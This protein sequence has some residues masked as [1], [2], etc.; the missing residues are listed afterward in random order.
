MRLPH[1][2]LPGALL[3]LATPL[4]AQQLARQDLALLDVTRGEA[5]VRRELALGKD[6]LERA[7]GTN[8]WALYREAVRHFEQAALD[9]PGA[10]EPWFGL[11][12]TRLALY[13]TGA[14]PVF[15][16]TQPPGQDTREAWARDIRSALVRQ[17]DHLGALTSLTHVVLPQGDRSQPDW[18][19]EVIEAAPAVPGAPNDLQLVRGRLLRQEARY[20]DA[21][22]ALDAYVAGGGDPSVAAYERA[23]ALAGAG[24]LA[25][26]AAAYDAGLAALTPAGRDA[27]LRDL[28]WITEPAELAPL[29]RITDPAAT[30][31]AIARFWSARDAAD[32]R[33]EGERLRE[34][35]RRWAV[36]ERRY[37]VQ[38]PERRTLFHEPWAPIAPCV[39]RDSFS[40]SQAGTREGVDP[41]DPRRAERILDDRGLMYL[42]HGEPLRVV[43]T[44]GAGDR[45]QEEAAKV[46]RAELEASGIPRDL[47]EA[48][49]GLR[50][51]TGDLLG[52]T[53]T[54]EV[55]T[56]FID[57]RVRSFLFTGSRW[58]GN[59][60]PTTLSANTGSGELALLR[61]QVDP[62]YYTVWSRYENPFPPK[63]PVECLPSV[64]RMARV[65]REDLV[66]GGSSD[67]APLV[68]P[69][70]ALP[71]VQVAAV[72]DAA[73][74]AGRA[75]VAW[76]IP[77]D[78]LVPARTEH[79]VV[80][81][82][83][84]RLTAVDS[85]GDV[86]RAEGELQLAAQDS[87]V[88]GQ[89]LSGTLELPL[90]AGA[91]QVGVAFWQPDERHGGAV[92]VKEVRLATGAVTLSD[93]LLGR[94]EELVR[95]NGVPVNPLNTW[96]RDGTMQVYAELRGVPAGAEYRAAIEVR[97]LD[98]A[99]GR[100]LVSVT[101]QAR[102]DGAVTLF[103]RTLDLGRLRPGTYRLTLR[104][105]APGGT[106]LARERVFEIL[107]P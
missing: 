49:L 31:R 101:S 60:A 92:Q 2:A 50:Q 58:L 25:A 105:T 107:A 61:A 38:D 33:G 52:G 45:A 85:A 70:P 10:A 6:A 84:W 48:E 21:L 57:G 64:Q 78:H 94:E 80:Y 44:S 81:P 75:A 104:V 71:S 17:P 66:A 39:P 98:H 77:G 63:V 23:R 102:S 86:H 24:D 95:W 73:Q 28:A 90:P 89:F 56:Y 83:R 42:R 65:A 40:L 5:A 96:R 9:D 91:W 26:A 30:A 55:W 88:A 19:R 106:E 8:D 43:W 37:R 99:R 3:L 103:R 59:F 35:L 74:D 68:F 82:L 46:T 20:P 29:E 22:A 32:V 4:A 11:A 67:D 76:A 16:P 62:R 27:Y 34:H 18:L 36:A 100:P 53:N 12:L 93:L 72:G 7:T 47:V 69:V 51:R 97:Q 14:N 54:A 87:L 41:L 15:S 13:E 1:L 79:G